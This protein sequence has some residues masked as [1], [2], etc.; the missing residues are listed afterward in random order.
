MMNSLICTTYCQGDQIKE[1]LQH[2]WDRWA[3]HT[4]FWPEGKISCGRHRLRWKDGMKIV[5]KECRM[6]FLTQNGSSGGFCEHNNKPFGSIKCGIYHSS[7]TTFS[8]PR[9]TSC[10]QCILTGIG[11]KP[12]KILNIAI[13]KNPVLCN[14]LYR[15]IISG[16]NVNLQESPWYPFYF[17][18][19]VDR[20]YELLAQHVVS[21]CFLKVSS[22]F[23]VHTCQFQFSI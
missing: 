21:E 12:L 20:K 16:K 11:M 14:W 8:P 23:T 17:I 1:V 15:A 18:P 6:L 19:F 3:L 13:V 22:S 2:A 9:T 4:E 10:S 5:C 7:V